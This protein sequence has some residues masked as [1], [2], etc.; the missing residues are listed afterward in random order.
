MCVCTCVIP[1]YCSLEC[2][3]RNTIVPLTISRTRA[4][5]HEAIYNY[6]TA[7]AHYYTCLHLVWN[8]VVTLKLF[9]HSIR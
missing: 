7:G 3:R 4:T 2:L 5:F 9:M 8:V 1:K 6:K